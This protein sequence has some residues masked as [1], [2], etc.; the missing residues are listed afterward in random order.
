MKPVWGIALLAAIGTVPLAAQDGNTDKNI[1]NRPLATRE[2]LQGA[3]QR[4]GASQV[5]MQTS[6]KRRFIRERRNTCSIIGSPAMRASGFP[7]NLDEAIL[8]GMIP[9]TRI[10]RALTIRRAF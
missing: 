4:A 7:G 8:A 9:T 6:V 1:V 5:A 2:E 3:L 10:D